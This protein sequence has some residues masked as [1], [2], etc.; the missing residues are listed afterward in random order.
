MD[1]KTCHE[2]KLLEK[3]HL[4]IV[5]VFLMNLIKADTLSVEVRIKGAENFTYVY[6]QFWRYED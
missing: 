4:S 6:E 5:T 3:V 1:M 2:V